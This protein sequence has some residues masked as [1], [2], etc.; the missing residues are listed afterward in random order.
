MNVLYTVLKL[1]SQQTQI[2][3]K[4]NYINTKTITDL[5]REKFLFIMRPSLQ[6]SLEN[7]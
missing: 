7:K 3:H 1:Q 5:L 2:N 6:M 4:D